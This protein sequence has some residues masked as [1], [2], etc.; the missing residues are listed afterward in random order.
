MRRKNFKA[1][2]FAFCFAA[3]LLTSCSGDKK[4]IK[5]EITD[6]TAETTSADNSTDNNGSSDSNN[7][8]DIAG[9]NNNDISSDNAGS[10]DNKNDITEKPETMVVEVT[11]NDGA[12]VTDEKNEPVTQVVTVTK[13]PSLTQKPQKN[14]SSTS[15]SSS[16]N[17][18]NNTSASNFDKVRAGLW[19]AN[20]KD[21]KFLTLKEDGALVKVTVKINSD[22]KP[23]NYEIGLVSETGIDRCSNFCN[24]KADL[25]VEFDPAIISVGGT[26][27]PDKTD[28][29]GILF[30]MTNASAN[31][32]DTVTL[33]GN[34]HN[35]KST[36][37][38]IAGFTVFMHYDS[39]V[40]TIEKIEATELTS[41]GDF[42]SN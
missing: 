12:V 33:Y 5:S 9:S 15:D 36:N 39:S 27:Q 21:K 31:P 1:G 16:Q 26:A 11:G 34:I 10:A 18:N 25:K 42:I 17:D 28:A 35:L 41:G 24:D 19:I 20:T 2:L 32:G 14:Q 13:Q 22:A 23:G 37:N 38:E 29:S 4:P 6:S 40:M 8:D 7:N 3:M 30:S